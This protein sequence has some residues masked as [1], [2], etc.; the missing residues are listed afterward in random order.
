MWK[1][2]K[3]SAG[4]SLVEAALITPLLLMLTLS[5]VDFGVLFYAWLVL[6]NGVSQATR[7]GVTGNQSPGLSREDSIKVAMRNATPTLTI[8]D[9]AITFSYLPSGDTTWH[10]GAGGPNDVQKVTVRYSW[11]M[12]T[13][14][15]KALFPGG[16]VMLTVES[17]MKNEPRF[18]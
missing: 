6:E 15:V 17:A 14:F 11:S 7:Y 12:L 2:I 3:D 8:P 5:M 10:T 13:P 1:R 16:A 9:G 4:T 18:Q